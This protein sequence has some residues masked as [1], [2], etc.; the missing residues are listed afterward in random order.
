MYASVNLEEDILVT[1]SCGVAVVSRQLPDVVSRLHSSFS[2]SYGTV[3]AGLSPSCRLMYCWCFL[4]VVDPSI[5]EILVTRFRVAFVGVLQRLALRRLYLL[6][7]RR[8]FSL[9]CGTTEC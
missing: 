2:R 5:E 4:L 8:R 9:A 1:R 6:I 3:S 7:F